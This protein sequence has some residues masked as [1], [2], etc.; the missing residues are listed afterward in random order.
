[1]AEIDKEL[2]NLEANERHARLMLD[3]ANNSIQWIDILLRAGITID[4]SAQI[5]SLRRDRDTFAASADHSARYGRA[6]TAVIHRIVEDNMDRLSMA[7]VQEMI[8]KEIQNQLG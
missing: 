4:V 1:M 6:Q 5:E 2:N 3:Q 7:D 8:E